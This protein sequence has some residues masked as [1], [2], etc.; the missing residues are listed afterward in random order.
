MITEQDDTSSETAAVAPPQP[1]FSKEFDPLDS[2]SA[3][4]GEEDG[5]GDDGQ[6]GVDAAK[7]FDQLSL[8]SRGTNREFQVS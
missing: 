2:G 1:E 5:H 4:L 7:S 3:P 6:R 8:S